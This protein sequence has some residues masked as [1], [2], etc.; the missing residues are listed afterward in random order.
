LEQSWFMEFICSVNGNEHHQSSWL[1]P[2]TP[3][4][5]PIFRLYSQEIL[6][7]EQQNL[8][9]LRLYFFGPEHK[10]CENLVCKKKRVDG[11]ICLKSFLTFMMFEGF[12]FIIFGD[13]IFLLNL[14]S[15]YAFLVDFEM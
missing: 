8:P 15:N 3:D 7:L 4:F 14:C 12:F 11:F 9:L 10:A 2:I 13:L 1:V 6:P 5:L